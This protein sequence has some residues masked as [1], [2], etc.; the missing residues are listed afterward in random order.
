[1]STGGRRTSGS[2][3]PTIMPETSSSP[4]SASNTTSATPPPH[5]HA[6]SSS[7]GKMASHHPRHFPNLQGDSVANQL[8]QAEVARLQSGNFTSPPPPEMSSGATPAPR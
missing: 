2:R 4:P 6:R 1:M 5:R 8:N 7:H 3:I